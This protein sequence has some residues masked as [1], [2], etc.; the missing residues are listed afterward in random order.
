MKGIPKNCWLVD[1]EF[2]QPDG[3][4][5]RP[6]CMVA[7][8]FHTGENH[9]LW[10]W[11]DSPATLPFPLDEDALYVSYLASAELSCHLALDWALPVHVLD[12][13]AE[14]CAMTSGLT[15]PEGRKLLGALSF[16]GIQGIDAEDKKDMRDLAI[17][18]G[19]F[20]DSEKE[21]WSTTVNLTP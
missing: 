17:R 8:N 5:P 10:L 9:H 14:F 16:F 12:L 15:L 21:H 7:R 6:V 20:T 19:P 4:L 18:G 3:E 13:Y 11:D 1:F 2:H